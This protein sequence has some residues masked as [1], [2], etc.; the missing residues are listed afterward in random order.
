MANIL[1]NTLSLQDKLS[2]KLSKITITT[3]MALGKFAKLELQ[4]KDVSKKFNQLGTNVTSLQSK[5]QLL[6]AERDLLPIG[7]LSAIRKYNSE[8]IKLENTA[9]KLQLHSLKKSTMLFRQLCLRGNVCR[10]LNHLT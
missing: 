9:T 3:D 8:I 4:S 2:A 7:S 5:I 6:K 10:I 1:E